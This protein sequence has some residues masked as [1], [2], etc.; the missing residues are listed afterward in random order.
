MAWL[1]DF[2][3]IYRARDKNK[4]HVNRSRINRFRATLQSCELKEIHLQNR[5]FTWSNERENPTMC[6]LDSFFCNAE[7]DT[8]FSTHLLHA[9]SSL[10]SDHCP[11]LLAMTRG[12]GGLEP[13]SL[14]FFGLLCPALWRWSKRLGSSR[15]SMLSHIKSCSINSRRWLSAFPNG[16]GAFSPRQ[17]FTYMPPYW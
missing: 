10:L 7:W 9:L 2:N 8:T 3:Q 16:V 15:S 14:K 17:R 12:L 1:G 13:S 4:R 5:R 6:K 11:L